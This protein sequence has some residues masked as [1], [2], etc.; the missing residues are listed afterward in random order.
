VV[1]FEDEL[2]DNGIA[3]LSVKIVSVAALDVYI[4]LTNIRYSA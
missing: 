4:E 1:L 2:H 3:N